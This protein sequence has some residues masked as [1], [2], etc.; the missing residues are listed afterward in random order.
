[1]QSR[2]IKKEKAI[3]MLVSAFIKEIGLSP[4]SENLYI[5]IFN[6]ITEELEN[7]E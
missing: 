5:N 7:Y 2:G 6:K 1:M 3:L 4:S